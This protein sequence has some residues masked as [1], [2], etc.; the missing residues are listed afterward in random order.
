VDVYAYFNNDPHAAAVLDATV[1][2]RLATTAGMRVTRTPRK[3]PAP[4]TG[5]AT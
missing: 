4:S 3:L 1:F 5:T 2:A